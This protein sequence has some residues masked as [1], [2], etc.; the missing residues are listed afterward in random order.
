ME[1]G[2][3]RAIDE[4]PQIRSVLER[5]HPP[6]AAP[7]IAENTVAVLLYPS[8][9]GRAIQTSA[10]RDLQEL[11]ETSRRMK[12]DNRPIVGEHIGTEVKWIE[13]WNSFSEWT[14]IGRGGFGDVFRVR[15]RQTNKAF[16][17]L[18]AI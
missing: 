12:G 3:K 7:E 2:Q 1:C 18:C 15:E 5:F 17:S 14:R 16:L 8:R 4:D 9:S 6:I 13:F 10:K 11:H